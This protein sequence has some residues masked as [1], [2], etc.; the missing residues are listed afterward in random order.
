MAADIGNLDY[1]VLFAQDPPDSNIGWPASLEMAM[2]AI[3]PELA[4]IWPISLNRTR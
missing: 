4:V 3:L 2:M 1:F